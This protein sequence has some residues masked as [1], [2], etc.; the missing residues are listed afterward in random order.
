M[1]ALR[2]SDRKV[3]KMKEEKW[4]AFGFGLMCGI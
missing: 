3:K 2:E 1:W 4:V